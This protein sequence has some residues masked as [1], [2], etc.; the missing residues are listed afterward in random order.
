MK[1]DGNEA[2]KAVGGCET[3][4]NAAI[5]C[6]LGALDLGSG[7]LSLFRRPF[8]KTRKATQRQL[9]QL[10]VDMKQQQRLVASQPTAVCMHHASHVM[11][12]HDVN[13]TFFLFFF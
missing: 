7:C 4:G 8:A 5:S 10:Q 3:E 6:G 9:L 1:R 11:N 13:I 2:L 12:Y